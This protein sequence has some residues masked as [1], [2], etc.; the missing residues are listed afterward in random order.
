MKLLA[1]QFLKAD[2]ENQQISLLPPTQKSGFL[3]R[4]FYIIDE[5]RWKIGKDK[6]SHIPAGL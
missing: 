3:Y 2:F 4:A 1:E 6:K 5:K